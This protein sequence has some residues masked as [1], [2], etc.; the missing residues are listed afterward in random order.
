MPRAKNQT[1]TLRTTREIKDLLRMAAEREHRSVA[2]MVE[3]LVLEYA[4]QAKLSPPSQ[5][6]AAT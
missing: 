2:S 1:L 6:K 4:R 5:K 3:I